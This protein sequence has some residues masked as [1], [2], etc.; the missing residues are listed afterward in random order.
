MDSTTMMNAHM[1]HAPFYFYTPDSRPDSRHHGHFQQLHPQQVMCQMPMY[2]M[3]PTL[4]S[5]PIYSRPNSS[6]SQQAPGAPPTLYSNGPGVMTPVA[7]PQPAASYKPTILLETDGLNDSMYF[8]STPPLSSAGS[9]IS[10]P[11]S[12]DM[13]QTPMN[14]MFSGLDGIDGIEDVKETLQ[15]VEIAALDWS[16]CGSPPMTPVYLQQAQSHL[17]KGVSLQTLTATSSN[18]NLV[19]SIKSESPSDLLSSTTSCPSLSPSPVPYARSVAS[20]QDLDFCDP[21]NLLVGTSGPSTSIAPELS[22]FPCLGEDDLRD[23][24]F[25]N[26]LVNFGSLDDSRRPRACTGSSVVSLGLGE[27][28][29]SFDDAESFVTGVTS[30][31]ASLSD[32]DDHQVKRRKISTDC[33]SPMPV[34]DVA[35][36]SA[37]TASVPEQSS[38]QQQEERGAST[39]EANNSSGSDAATPGASLPSAPNRRGRK[40]SLTEDPSKTFV[41]ELCNR[42]FRRQEHLKRHYRSLH[43]HDKPFECHECG[44]KFSRSDNLAQ[45]ARTH[46]AGALVLDLIDEHSMHS[47]DGMIGGAHATVGDD[48]KHFGN[49]LFTIASEVPGSSSESDCGS[50]ADDSKKKRKR[51]D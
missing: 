6:C 38:N 28:D 34:M 9:S 12:C 49:V 15:P 26:E 45:H 40:Q 5:T 44:K 10:S 42:R 50:D 33:C 35:A 31:V 4:P 14:P 51:A 36:D 13:L 23:D 39:S 1:G 16:T 30:P 46:G 22:S 3:V 48:Y 8:P 41:C 32:C 25:V 20:E 11:N 17:G 18:L 2:P 19:T 27:E 7:S 29:F 21:R 43:T 24:D 47:Y 37:N